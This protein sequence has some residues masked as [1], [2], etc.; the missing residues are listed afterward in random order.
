[1]GN[2]DTVCMRHAWPL[3]QGFRASRASA[4]SAV[5][6]HE[7]ARG[8]HALMEGEPCLAS[9]NDLHHGDMGYV[10]TSHEQGRGAHAHMKCEGAGGSCVS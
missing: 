2:G 1:M 4:V 8:A 9:S 10:G 3:E 6:S 5:Q 7:Q